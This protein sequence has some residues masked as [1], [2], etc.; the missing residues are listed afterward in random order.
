[1]RHVEVYNGEVAAL[2]LAAGRATSLAEEDPS[3]RHLHFFA[4]NTAVIAT[5]FDPKPRSGQLY[6][7]KFH[8][9]ICDFLDGNPERTVEIAWSPGYSDIIGN[10]HAHE[11]AKEGT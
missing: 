11:L 9:K 8:Q 2:A 6:A 10:E 3:I 1:M 5:I 7:F 4:N